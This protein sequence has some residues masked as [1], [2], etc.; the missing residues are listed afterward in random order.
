MLVFKDCTAWWETL[1]DA[2]KRWVHMYFHDIKNMPQEVFNVEASLVS[3]KFMAVDKGIE[4]GN[5]VS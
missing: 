2:Q 1:S 5:T 4:C 3:H